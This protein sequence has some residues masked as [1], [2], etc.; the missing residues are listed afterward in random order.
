[1]P[2]ERGGEGE[3]AQRAAEGAAGAGEGGGA[4]NVHG[5]L[6]GGVGPEIGSGP[7]RTTRRGPGHDEYSL[8]ADGREAETQP[9]MPPSMTGAAEGRLASCVLVLPATEF[10][11]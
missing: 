3:A 6:Q 9:A 4:A 10:V 2:R 11:S 8:P 1:M 7:H 5:F